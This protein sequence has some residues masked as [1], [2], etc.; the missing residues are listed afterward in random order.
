MDPTRRQ[1]LRWGGIALTLP[2]LPSLQPATALAQVAPPKTRFIGCFFPAGAAMPSGANGD[3]TRAGAL[4]PL[5][6]MGVDA[7]VAVLRG[8][9][10]NQELDAHWSGTAAFLSCNRAGIY[11][12]SENMGQRCG[13]SFDQYVAD[14]QSTKVRSLHAAWSALS[15]WD[16]GT[17]AVYPVNYLN[18]IAWRDERN[19]IVNTR[20]PL[21]LFTRVFGDGTSITDPHVMYLLDRKQSILDGVTV[22]LQRFRSSLPADERAKMDN[23]E[24]GI[25]D[26]EHEIA[27]SREQY[28]CNGTGVVTA[29]TDMYVRTMRTYQ[30]IVVHAMM[31][32]A[33]R[34]A[35]IMYHEGIG[36]APTSGAL[37]DKQHY[38]AHSDWNELGNINRLQ[39]GLWAEM[40]ADLKA[41]D[42]LKSTVVMLGSNMSDGTVHLPANVPMIFASDGPELRLG[43]EI[44]GS[45]QLGNTEMNRNM[46]DIF[47]D[48]SKLYGM[49][50]PSFGEGRWK[51]SGTPS[52]L[53]AV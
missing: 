38:C 46:A 51:N 27:T 31:C 41:N 26:V 45:T 10:S 22:E 40:I 24:S 5:A 3:W 19:P 17:D 48:L 4:A 52:G 44:V 8:F 36:D 42:L 15:A 28:T 35:T 25:R 32:D 11:G 6:A 43:G 9:R 37:P 16:P 49:N 30:R 34:A 53:L 39:V 12:G 21:T 2:L 47:M 29:D 23:F 1:V 18:S 13:K 20:D 7:N 50:L 33:T 14:L